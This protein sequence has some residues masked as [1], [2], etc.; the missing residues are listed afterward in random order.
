MK[1]DAVLWLVYKSVEFVME[2]MDNKSK[3]WLSRL[4]YLKLNRQTSKINCNNE[5][6]LQRNLSAV[7]NGD[8]ST[9]RTLHLQRR[10]S[11]QRTLVNMQNRMKSVF[12]QNGNNS[13]MRYPRES[14]NTNSRV[15]RNFVWGKVTVTHNV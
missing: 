5:S 10:N 7:D 14:L 4:K 2:K 1:V 6:N 12:R 11:F 8:L 3:S 9:H 15:S 13:N